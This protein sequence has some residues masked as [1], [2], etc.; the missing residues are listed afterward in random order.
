MRTHMVADERPPAGRHV[1]AV[2]AQDLGA[3]GAADGAVDHGQDVGDA[4]LVDV[5]QRIV[6][7]QEQACRMIYPPPLMLKRFGHMHSL[8][9]VGRL[10]FCTR[11][12]HATATSPGRISS[13][14]WV[15]TLPPMLILHRQHDCAMMS[16]CH[17]RYQEPEMLACR[18]RRLQPRLHYSQLR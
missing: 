7:A 16:R 13:G 15:L 6:A 14:A 11:R 17:G 3:H 1:L 12:R 18:H 9:D 5:R 10:S 8:E 2:A 4:Q